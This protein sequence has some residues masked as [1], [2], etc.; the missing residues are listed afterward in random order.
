MKIGEYEQMMAYLTRPGFNG[1]GSSEVVEIDF[2][3]AEDKAFQDMMKAYKYYL[4]TGGKK[5]L[6]DYMR[7][8][9]GAGKFKG[10]G[11]EHFRATGGRVNLADG[12]EEIVEPPKSMQMDTTTSNP[13][14][15][16]DITDFRND[17]EIF[18]LAYHNNT[19]PT[20]D[21]ADRLNAFAKKGVDAGTFTMQEAADAVKDLQLYV[22]DR[23]RYQRLRDVVPEGIGTVER[24]ERA[25]GGGVI[26]GEDLGTREGFNRPLIPVSELPK[27]Q[28]KYINNWLKNNPD[29]KWEELTN[30]Q[31]NMLKKGQNVGVGYGATTP[32]GA[33]NPLF[34]PLSKKGEEIAKKVYGTTDISKEKRLR[35]N[36]GEITMDTKPVKF[37]KGKGISLKM[38]RGSEK[39]TDIVFPDKQMEKDFIK[40]IRARV[41][42]PQKAVVDFSNKELA[43]LFP[44]S[45][46]QAGRAV[47]YFV[48]KLNLKYATVPSKTSA[49]IIKNTKNLI[50]QTSSFLQENRIRSAKTN[51]LQ[52]LDLQKKMDTAHRVSKTH[53]AKLGLEFNTDIMGID[54]RLI[55]Q[56]IVKPSEIQL[57]RLYR[58]QYDIF[59]KLKKNPNSTELKNNLK[60]INKQVT[61]I[62]KNTSGRLV[63]VTIDPDTL[64]TSFQGIKKKYSF[65]NV[66]GDSMTMK[67]LENIPKEDQVKFLTKQLPKAIDLEVKRGFVPNDFKNI[68][69]N[70][71]SQKSILNYAKQKAPELI[72]PLKKAFLNP[73]SKVSLKLFSQ[74]P[75]ITTAGLVGYGAYKGMGFDQEVRADDMSK[76]IDPGVAVSQEQ[77]DTG[78]PAEAVAAG[79]VGAVKYG[80]QLLKILQNVGRGTI[81]TLGSLPAAV[82]Y[83]GLETKAGMDEG[84][85][86]TD[87]VTEPMVGLNLLLPETVKK[88]GPLMAKGAR[89]STPVGA[90]I[91][92]I[93]TLKNRAQ[94]MMQEA[95]A[96]TK[97]P[98][99]EDLIDEYAAKQYRG[100]ELGGRVGFADGPDDPSKRKFMKILGGLTALPFVGKF[101]KTAEPIAEVAPKIVETAKGA[102]PYF[103]KLVD[104]IKKFGE[105][106]TRQL[107]SSEREQVTSYRTSD[108]DYELYEDLN[109]GSQQIKIR[110]GDPDGSGGYKEQELTL[111]KGQS[112]ESAG[113]VPD[114][115]D[116]YTVRPDDDGKLKDVEEGIE[117]IDDLI[118]ELGPE[119]ISVKELQDMGYDVDRLGPVTKK[120]LGIK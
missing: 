25:I 63:G 102:P 14:P 7:M 21:I 92:G 29:K 108:A 72:A 82:G 100:Y 22:K 61:D 68:L 27:D 117:D 62:V 112:D 36:R 60:D 54:S 74:F 111:T 88:L 120:K 89:I 103:F 70:P 43:E 9:T 34:E 107:K 101:F 51:I 55:N 33:D 19:L 99:Q 113:V 71:D 41:L 37:E 110:K 8:S 50:K 1:G 79:S 13:I 94:A 24:E 26:E 90:T 85:S 20:A 32:K 118:D 56:I 39:P 6:K 2:G 49:D 93:G 15:E 48:D 65:S 69:S 59:E 58:K 47:R 67:E 3:S 42:Q 116:E 84:K 96:L 16:Y 38:K 91:T 35:I 106:V 46:K 80:P 119:N 23:A 87:A 105:D 97:T 11:R 4:S 78:I 76:P 31:R 109:T 44:I 114:E 10:G 12:T 28:Q 5:S 45:E 81:K 104:K 95:D 77:T 57:D 40:A 64:E 98:Y 75:A 66:L 115:Y 30:N 52:D 18:V 86:F 83:A 53:M 73:T 17:A